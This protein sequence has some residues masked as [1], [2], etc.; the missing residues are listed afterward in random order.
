[1]PSPVVECSGRLIVN[2]GWD[3]EK[4]FSSTSREWRVR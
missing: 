4:D 2:L 1:M 3:G